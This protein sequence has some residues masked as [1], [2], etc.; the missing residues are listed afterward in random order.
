M[1][2]VL[3]YRSLDDVTNVSIQVSLDGTAVDSAQ[4]TKT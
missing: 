2:V 3:A 1:S 4:L